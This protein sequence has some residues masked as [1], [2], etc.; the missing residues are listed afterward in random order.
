[1]GE[2]IK[3]LIKHLTILYDLQRCHKSPP[4]SKKGVFRVEYLFH[5]YIDNLLDNISIDNVFIFE[6]S[7]GQVYQIGR[8][9]LQEPLVFLYFAEFD[10]LDRIHL[11]HLLDEVFEVGRKV[12]IHGVATALDQPE[13]NGQ[14]RVIKRQ[15]TA[16][17]RV[18]DHP[19]G[20]D[21]DFL[22]RVGL[23]RNYLRCGIIWRPTSSL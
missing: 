7:V 13:Q 20:P 1:M 12:A 17:H 11:Q 18:E 21:I 4:I 9:V 5:T 10:A 23:P 2:Y 15:L 3:H 8:Q 14:L 6:R 22:S 19:A 16:D